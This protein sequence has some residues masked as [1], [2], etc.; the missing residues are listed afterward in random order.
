M[1]M[2]EI[3]PFEKNRTTLWFFI[4]VYSLC[5]LITSTRLTPC[6]SAQCCRA[7]GTEVSNLK[8]TTAHVEMCTRCIKN[9]FSDVLLYS[10]L[11]NF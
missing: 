7:A 9:S 1:K 3:E 6:S 8:H 4:W 10:P 2:K 5:L 11:W